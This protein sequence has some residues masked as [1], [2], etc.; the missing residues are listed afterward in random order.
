MSFG[1]ATRLGN[2]NGLRLPAAERG[3]K[4]VGLGV[5]LTI[6]GKNQEWAQEAT[7]SPELAGSGS[8]S[9][10]DA[11]LECVELVG[12]SVLERL[13]ERFVAIEVQCISV[14][15]EASSL[16]RI[17]LFR[18]AFGNVTIKAVKDLDSAISE[19]LGLFSQKGITHSFVNSANAYAE[20]DLL[21]LFCF[22][23]ESR[24]PIT[25]TF[26]KEG[27]L[28]LW[29]VDCSKLQ[30]PE[31]ETSLNHVGQNGAP[32]YFIREYVNRLFSP[33][34]MRRLSA[35][36][37]RRS[38][39]TAPCGKQVRPGVWID[40]GGEVHRRARIVAPAYIGCGSKIRADALVTRFSDIER[41]CCIDSGTVIEDSS[42]LANTTV[43]ICL[44]L[45]HA[46]ASG[47]QLWNLERNVAVEIVD[48]KVMRFTTA[49][50]HYLRPT[51]EPIEVPEDA[52]VSQKPTMPG[53]W[54]F[55]NN[56]SQE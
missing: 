28:D 12:S 50:R 44:D 48:P 20:T 40:Q 25:R 7:R 10:L 5:V 8:L 34:D 55:G 23:R 36:I 46:V 4:S 54:Q 52:V 56:F 19:E 16:T 2:V 26:D 24:Q 43:G 31:F 38:C 39:E 18:A 13:I 33:L 32:K 51:N 42:I 9:F 14:L 21:D 22:H 3:R 29:V 1:K 53:T 15:A 11:P 6:S 49:P 27:P 35:D 41:D 37:L 17:P 47:N 30:R 45:C